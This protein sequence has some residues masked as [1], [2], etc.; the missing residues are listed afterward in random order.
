MHEIRNSGGLLK[1][2]TAFALLRLRYRC[3]TVA[4]VILGITFTLSTSHV[5]QSWLTNTLVA[6]MGLAVIPVCV[7]INWSAVKARAEQKAGYTTL[8][9]EL[10]ELEQRDPYLGRAIRKPGQEYLQR[11]D[12]LAIIQAAKEEAE[13][14]R[15]PTDISSSTSAT[16]RTE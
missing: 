5:P 9:N 15:Q 4:L 1:G 2:P 10:K 3:T 11:A 12:F 8:R 6:A 7:L 16:G 14:L 13:S